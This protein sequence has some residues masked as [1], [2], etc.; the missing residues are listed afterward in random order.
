MT[1]DVTEKNISYN[2]ETLDQTPEQHNTQDT[3]NGNSVGSIL[4]PYNIIMDDHLKQVEDLRQLFMDEYQ[5]NPD[6]YDRIDYSKIIDKSQ[7]WHCW[8]HLNQY[9]FN[10]EKAFDNMK[11]SLKWRK[12]NSVNHLKNDDF[13][14]EFWLYGPILQCGRNKDGNSVVYMIGS[15]FK[16]PKDK[17]R[18]QFKNYICNV[19]NT[20][21]NSLTPKEKVVIIFDD[22]NTTI[23]NFDLD[24]MRWA[25]SFV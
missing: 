2:G 15:L 22:S 20:Q 12:E 4:S 19:L 18:N 10:M 25:V 6:Q 23:M 9:Q 3:S 17:M 5:S 7:P 21:D 1:N 24:L 13:A 14:K 16:P 11:N 8:R